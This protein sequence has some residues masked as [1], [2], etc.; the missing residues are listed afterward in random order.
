MYQRKTQDGKK[1]GDKC[2][3]VKWRTENSVILQRKVGKV[4]SGFKMKMRCTN[5]VTMTHIYHIMNHIMTHVMTHIIHLWLIAF[6]RKLSCLKLAS[7]SLTEENKNRVGIGHVIKVKNPESVW[8]SLNHWIEQDFSSFGP[9]FAFVRICS[10]KS[11]RF[12]KHK[13]SNIPTILLSSLVYLI[14]KVSTFDRVLFGYNWSMK[15]NK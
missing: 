12:M 11:R 7:C 1:E 3:L 13:D 6:W 14:N 4:N 10:A 8:I 9:W 5:D 15:P 2:I